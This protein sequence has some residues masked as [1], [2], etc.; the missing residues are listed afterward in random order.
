MFGL[1]GVHCGPDITVP[2]AASLAGLPAAGARRALAELTRTHLASEHVPGRFSCHDLLRAYAAE[3]ASELPEAER[4]AAT[5]RMLDHYLHTAYSASRLIHPYRDPI[6][7]HLPPPVV[8][9]EELGGRE[10]AMEWFRAERQVLLAVTRQAAADGRFGEH[11]WQLPW[12]MAM[13]LNWD[14][15]WAELVATQEAA[16]AAALRAGDHA[17]Q[18]EAHRFL[19]LAQVRFGAV[20]EGTS[21]LAAVLELGRQ[22]GSSTLQARAHLELGRVANV[23]GRSTDALDH[24]EQALRLYQAAE[25][26]PGQ[27]SA[28]NSAGWSCALLGRHHEALRHCERAL[29]LHRE[30]G[31]RS[32]EAAT[33]DSVGYAHHQLGDYARAVS[34][35]QESIEAFDGA[36]DAH[37][38]AQAFTH[39]GD[40]HQG[41]GDASAARHAWRQALAI[42]EGLQHP[43]AE[44]VRSRLAR[45]Q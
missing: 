17:G 14:G 5:H 10:Q 20:D 2:A 21:H 35:Y 12:A 39:L 23:R 36:D 40:A 15:Y 6:A 44:Q 42:L 3:Q 37:H 41:S 22:L 19:G 13:F 25:Y 18:A 38:R 1:L 7:R 4:R 24:A 8:C 32:G 28:L 31:N 34:Y 11:A 43:E 9:P 33:L 45:P 29:E 27:A 26:R 16:L 30:L